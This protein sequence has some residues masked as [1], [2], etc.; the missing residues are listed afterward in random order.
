WRF[1]FDLLHRPYA[2][3]YLVAA[4]LAKVMPLAAAMRIVVA[5]CTI[6][7]VVGLRMLLAATERPRH[8]ALL[9]VPFAF[10]SL[11]FW[12]FLNFIAGTGLMLV[13]LALVVRIAREPT[14][15]TQRSIGLGLL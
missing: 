8:L 12:G 7:P 2:S 9:A 3:V 14:R 5:A 6:I 13:A 15:R 11:W 4:A 1:A 10:G